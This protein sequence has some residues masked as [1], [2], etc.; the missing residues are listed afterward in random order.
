MTNL[1]ETDREEMERVIIGRGSTHKV[2]LCVDKTSSV[3]QWE[4]VSTQY[5][6]AF[7]V[8]H[9][10]EEGNGK[11]SKSELVKCPYPLPL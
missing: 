10:G 7:D 1:T 6:I 8:Y 2:K 11:K 3:I 4:F 5:D 9:K